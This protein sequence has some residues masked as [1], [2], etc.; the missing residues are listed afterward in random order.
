MEFGVF[1]DDEKETLRRHRQFNE[2]VLEY[3]K[4][5]DTNKGKEQG[6]YLSKYFKANKRFVDELEKYEKS[7]E[8]VQFYHRQLYRLSETDDIN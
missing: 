7:K 3:E 4:I 5:L 8:E 2:Y 1:T 6:H